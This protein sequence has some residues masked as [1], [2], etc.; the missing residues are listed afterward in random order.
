MSTADT[1]FESP[2]PSNVFDPEYLDTLKSNSKWDPEGG[3]KTEWR[4]MGVQSV[5][6]YY[7]LSQA[8]KQRRI[9]NA[10]DL[11]SIHGVLMS[12][13]LDDCGEFRTHM[14][15]AG[16]Y[17][18]A[19]HNDVLSRVETTLSRFKDQI[20]SQS[21]HA[22]VIAT[23]LMLDFVT[24]HP[25][26]NGNGRMCRLLFSYALELMG[27]PFPVIFDSGHSR[28]Y[29]HYIDALKAAQTRNSLSYLLQI[30][31]MSVIATIVNYRD[32]T[33]EEVI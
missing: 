24:I 30:A 26:S 22:I 25:F 14:A 21:E 33:G 3:T 4:S 1:L 5:R 23:R 29:R 7:L 28:S 16:E 15:E 13:A 31:L 17:V 11:K 32:F 19:H 12:G 10:N 6:A 8:A 2:L 20:E 9:I 18:F 27:F